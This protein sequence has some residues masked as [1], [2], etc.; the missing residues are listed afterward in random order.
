MFHEGLLG[1]EVVECRGA[2]EEV[3][4]SFDFAD[5]GFACCVR[6]GECERVGMFIEKPSDECSLTNA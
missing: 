2:D 6:Y 3:I 4:P 1:D 5:S